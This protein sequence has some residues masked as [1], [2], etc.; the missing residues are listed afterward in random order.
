MRARIRKIKHMFT[1]EYTIDYILSRVQD[2]AGDLGLDAYRSN[3]TVCEAAHNPYG[4]RD[5]GPA[6][7]DDAFELAEPDE[8]PLSPWPLQ[9]A[10]LTGGLVLLMLALAH[11]H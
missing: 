3:S 10:W 1:Y 9:P 8:E 11:C 6:S 2:T 4:Q 7:E 5:S